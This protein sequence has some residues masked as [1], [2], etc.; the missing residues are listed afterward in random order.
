MTRGRIPDGARSRRDWHASDLLHV[1][2]LEVRVVK[3]QAPGHRMTNAE[4]GRQG[5]MHLGRARG[6]M[7]SPMIPRSALPRRS[8]WSY[9][10]R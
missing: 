6:C 1:F 7:R 3:R 8:G 2:R 9:R 5:H 4:A 10:L